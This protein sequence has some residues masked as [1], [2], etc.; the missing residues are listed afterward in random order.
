MLTVFLIG[1]VVVDAVPCAVG[2]PVRGDGKSGADSDGPFNARVDSRGGFSRDCVTGKLFLGGLVLG[3]G[4]RDAVG[5]S[6]GGLE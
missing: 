6:A 5:G 4:G 2:I 3:M 1:I